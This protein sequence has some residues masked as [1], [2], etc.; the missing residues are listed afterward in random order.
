MA[1]G[2]FRPFI[3]IRVEALALYHPY[4]VKSINI[5][6]RLIVKSETEPEVETFGLRG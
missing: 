6:E 1:A 3:K 2:L 4:K 5:K